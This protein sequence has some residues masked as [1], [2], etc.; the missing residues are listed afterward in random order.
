MSNI[1]IHKNNIVN[2]KTDAIVNA[3][4]T[5]LIPG[6]GVCGAI[7]AAAGTEK[8]E[9]ECAKHGHCD[10]GDAVITSA[11]DMANRFI[12]HAVGPKYTNGKHGELEQL[13]SCYQKSLELAK[14]NECH[15]IGFPLISAGVYGFPPAEAWEIAIESCRDFINSNKDYDINIV[16]VAKDREQVDLGKNVLASTPMDE[17]SA[18][19]EKH[20]RVYVADMG[21]FCE[22]EK[23]EFVA[24][25]ASEKFAKNYMKYLRGKERYHEKDIIIREITVPKPDTKDE[26]SV[27]A[28]A[29]TGEHLLPGEW[30]F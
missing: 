15:S 6:S 8:L 22:P 11:C 24:E 27:I 18:K 7:F 20:Y 21:K 5:H 25:F 14:T 17:V 13:Y 26:K 9:K 10:V 30:N 12:I 3:A 2:L 29:V 19:Q 1:E 28:C 4:N 23:Y 16:F